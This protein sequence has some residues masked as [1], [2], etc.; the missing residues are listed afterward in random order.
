MSSVRGT[1]LKALLISTAA[2]SVLY[3]G[4]GMFRPSYVF[5][6]SVVNILVIE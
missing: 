2:R 4:L 1:V 5:C 6:V 3:A